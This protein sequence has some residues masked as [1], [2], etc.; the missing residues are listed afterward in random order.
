MSNIRGGEEV[1]VAGCIAGIYYDGEEQRG[2]KSSGALSSIIR[3]Q[4][5][6]QL[7][8]HITRNNNIWR[9]RVLPCSGCCWS[10]PV[11]NGLM[12]LVAPRRMRRHG[13][14]MV[15]SGEPNTNSRYRTLESNNLLFK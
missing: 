2:E 5:I 8:T 10:K 15:V 12:N 1:T 11:R 9:A 6:R 14:G 3:Q 4:R 13:G 7:L